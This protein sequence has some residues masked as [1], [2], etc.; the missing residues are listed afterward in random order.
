[1][2]LEKGEI[3]KTLEGVVLDEKGIIYCVELLNAVENNLLRRREVH[4]KQIASFNKVNSNHPSIGAK[5]ELEKRRLLGIKKSLDLVTFIKDVALEDFQSKSLAL[6][7]EGV[8]T[9]LDI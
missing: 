9:S 6:I 3:L 2:A 4:L 5:L 1:M 8:D 7:E